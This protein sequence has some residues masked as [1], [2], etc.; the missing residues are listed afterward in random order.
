MGHE[1][2][3]SLL[4]LFLFQIC[5]YITHKCMLN[6]WQQ[7]HTAL[8]TQSKQEE[9]VFMMVSYDLGS[10]FWPWERGTGGCK[11]DTEMNW[12]ESGLVE[13]FD[14][15]SKCHSHQILGGGY[16]R[17]YNSSCCYS[18]WDSFNLWDRTI[19]PNITNTWILLN[20]SMPFHRCN[21]ST[22]L[23][24]M[25]FHFWSHESAE[26]PFSFPFQF[27]LLSKYFA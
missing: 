22:F 26:N 19:G 6:I 18:G 23:R 25:I 8:H 20:F 13:N 16:F 9:Y 24:S 4:L 1:Q 7:Q 14:G 11:T 5:M 10:I 17:D 27:F 15:K 2:I 3:W 12:T 21:R